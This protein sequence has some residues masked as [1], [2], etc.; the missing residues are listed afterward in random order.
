LTGFSYLEGPRWYQGRLW[1]S[2]LY[3]HQVLSAMGDG[4]D[5][6]VEAE[7]PGQPSG[8]GWLPDGRLLIVS[9]RDRKLL[10]RELSGT[11]VTHADLSDK[12]GGDPNDMVV[13]RRGRAFVGNFGFDL[14]AGESLKLASLLRVDPDGT[15]AEVADHLW[16]P[17]GIVITPDEVLLVTETF[18]NRITA[19]DI[20]V[21]GTLT[22]RREW[23]RFGDLPTETDIAKLLGQVAVAG[24]GCALDAEGAL[25]V[26]DAVNGRAVRVREGGEIIDEIRPGTGVFACAL[27]GDDGRTLF[28]CAAPDF[29]E[30]ACNNARKAAILA[31]RVKVAASGHAPC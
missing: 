20:A 8:L 13:D 15:V 24:D 12:T 14:R 3:T 29:D 21:G 9:M 31:V 17:N 22:D 7:V 2:D 27:G 10:R 30:E 25:W 16:F 5:V 23:A 28:I 11:L 18:G 26:A 4:A 6:H 19:F 1:F